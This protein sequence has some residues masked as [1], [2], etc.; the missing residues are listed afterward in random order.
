LQG[1]KEHV[2][3]SILLSDM[4]IRVTRRV[5]RVGGKVAVSLQPK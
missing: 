5:K 1:Q 3:I 2:G 4:T